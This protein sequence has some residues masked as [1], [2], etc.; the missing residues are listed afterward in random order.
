MNCRFVLSKRLPHLPSPTEDLDHVLGEGQT[1]LALL[2]WQG[3]KELRWNGKL[4]LLKSDESPLGD[5]GDRRVI[6]K[7]RMMKAILFDAGFFSR[8]GISHLGKRSP[9]FLN[10][11]NSH[12][13]QKK[14]SAF[15]ARRASGGSGG[16]LRD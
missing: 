11:V 8:R 6:L 3:V 14:G 16:V 7:P 2:A 5:T 10:T 4:C 15:T 13:Q 9:A 12:R 1:L